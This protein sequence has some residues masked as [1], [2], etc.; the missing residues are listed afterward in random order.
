M[1]RKYFASYMEDD[2]PK[3]KEF[4]DEQEAKKFCQKIQDKKEHC[5]LYMQ[6]GEKFW[7][8]VDCYG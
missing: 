4:E 1:E 7:E 2:K 6:E 3:L 5:N 8:R